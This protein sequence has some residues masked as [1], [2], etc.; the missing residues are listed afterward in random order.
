M[1]VLERLKR[2]DP[3]MTFF[4]ISVKAL[5]DEIEYLRLNNE[6]QRD[7]IREWVAYPHH[8]NCRCDPGETVR[9]ILP[10]QRVD[11]L[12]EDFAPK[13][14]VTGA[15]V[16][17][18]PQMEDVILS[19]PGVNLAIPINPTEYSVYYDHRFDPE[20]VKANITSRLRGPGKEYAC[21]RRD[22]W[23]SQMAAL[24]FREWLAEREKKGA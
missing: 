14:T 13:G 20:T 2:L 24:G 17:A 10:G 23:K 1:D 8:W 12:I 22:A 4:G 6:T 16:W 3:T 15:T 5:A 19:V 9:D 7:L 21:Y 11:V 18:D